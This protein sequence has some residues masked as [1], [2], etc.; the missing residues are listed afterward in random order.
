MSG[1]CAFFFLEDLGIHLLV[2]SAAAGMVC[3]V[4]A[5]A[6]HICLIVHFLL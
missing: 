3:V 6:D 5:L 1:I 4:V 2:L